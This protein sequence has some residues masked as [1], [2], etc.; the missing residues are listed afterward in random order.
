[1]RCN[2]TTALFGYTI[3]HEGGDLSFDGRDITASIAPLQSHRPGLP[4]QEQ[5]R[6][7]QRPWE[8]TVFYETHVLKASAN[9][10]HQ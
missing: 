5:Q 2:G 8:N 1:M 3:G 7:A 6:K 9:Y 4:S 10:I